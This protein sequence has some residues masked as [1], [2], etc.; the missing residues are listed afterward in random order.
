MRSGTGDAV[1]QREER[2]DEVDVFEKDV[3]HRGRELHV[4]EVP[5]PADAQLDKPVGQRLRTVL[6]H[7]EPGDVE[8]IFA[9]IVLQ[10]VH[11]ADDVVVDFGADKGGGDVEG[12][13][14]L[15]ADLLEVEVLEQGMAEV[16][17]TDDNQLVPIVDAQNVA[18]FGAQL[19]D[20]IAVSLLA[21]LTEA[22]QILPDL[23]GR[24]VH[25]AAQRIG[26]YAD[27]AFVI[28]VIQ[29]AIIPGQTMNDRI[30]NPLFF[31]GKPHPF[32]WI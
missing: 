12:G 20:V 3:R 25:F 7:G 21:E 10:L 5:E 24:D 22:A 8:V 4:R 26:G 1:A 6:R 16:A 32:A 17:G 13:V 18:D 27:D 23:G 29:I 15:E 30:G 14:N 11:R 9:D 31:H 19:G 28:E 2:V